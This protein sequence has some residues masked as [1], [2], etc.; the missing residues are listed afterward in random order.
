MRIVITAATAHELKGIESSI[1]PIF[2]DESKDFYVS[3]HKSGV[4]TLSATYSLIKLINTSK[5]N[6]IIQ[7]G[8]AG[9]FSENTPHG[10]VVAVKD[11][12]MGDV[13]VEEQGELKD[14]FDLN[15]ENKDEHPFTNRSLLNPWL[16]E[17]NV[18]KLNEVTGIT[19]NEITAR[20]DR[21]KQIKQKYNPSIE[22]MEG[23]PLHYV[24]LQSTVPFIQIRSISNYI[25]E[26]DKTKWDIKLALNN[27]QLKVLQYID[28]LYEVRLQAKK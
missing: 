17:F 15:L 4:G 19:V 22:S 2:L 10:T 28:A 23:A 24:A 26:R 7:V 1:N 13:G 8:I 27:L 12:F 21:I 25:G 11:E 20:E 9:S 14:L 3:F 16:P 6:L 18:L 5:P